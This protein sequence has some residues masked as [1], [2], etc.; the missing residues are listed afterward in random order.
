M[1]SE[2]V[3][4]LR[5]APANSRTL[6]RAATLHAALLACFL[7][8]APA[9]GAGSADDTA[10]QPSTTVAP[11]DLNAIWN[12]PSFRLSFIGGYGIHPDVEPR[13]SQ[14]DLALLELVRQLLPDELPA[15]EA[16]LRES[17]T[18]EC[19]AVLDLTLGGV[20]FQA[21]KLD[22]ALADYRN[23][24]AKFP[25]FRRAYRSIGLICT[26]KGQFEDAIAAFNKMIELGGAD[27][28]SYGLL[29]Y[30]HTNRQD[31]QPAEAAYRNALL[32]QP[33]NVE[34]R[35]GLTRSVFKQGKYEDAA[36]LLDV[37]IAAFPDKA[38][39]W[40]LQAHTYLG[41]KQ[42]LK[43]AVNLEALDAMGKA[44]ADNLYTL[45]EIYISE[46]L[47]EQAYTAYS[48]AIA[49]NTTQPPSKPIRAAEMLAARG[50]QAQAQALLEAIRTAWK[51]TL[52]DADR[53]R[54]LKLQA[55]LAMAN[56]GSTP[57]TVAVLE[58]VIQLD[59][60]DGDALMMLGEHYARSS[61]PDQA[62]LFY[63]R[64]AKLESF[65]PR[66][67]VKIAQVYVA[68]G[69]FNEALPLLRDAQAVRPR[70]DV[71]RYLEQ[72]ERA[73]RSKRS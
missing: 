65:A 7:C 46:N 36:S 10:P 71:A 59:P 30:C 62:I 26:R 49:K 54:V 32:L 11:P 17:V 53:R 63:E 55:R 23:A 45:G 61:S 16:L 51:D 5:S 57:E 18:P 69:R 3:R 4:S 28:Y 21:E 6:A 37:L 52:N 2:P 38:D 15:A 56:G 34:W 22:A 9:Q 33:E 12:D 72:V 35:L 25:S 60:L 29:G 67:K 1:T 44:S 66:A 58:E 41:L 19:S 13:I 70:E 50:G 14:D 27:A 73:A 39:F 42:P 40:V 48:R 64:A 43:A 8:A 20:R 68:Q 47:P 31:Y 24:V